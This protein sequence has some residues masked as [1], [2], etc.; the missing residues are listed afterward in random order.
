[1]ASGVAN[2]LISATD[3]DSVLSTAVESFREVLG[4][5]NSRI[6]VQP[7]QQQA[8]PMRSEPPAPT[9]VIPSPLSDTE[10]VA[11]D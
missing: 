8:L 4:A 1:M 11:G 9:E 5:V 2:R 10:R 3:V 6:H 7:F